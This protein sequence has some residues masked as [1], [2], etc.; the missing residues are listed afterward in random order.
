MTSTLHV[1]LAGLIDYAGLFPPAGESMEAATAKY[2]RYLEGPFR[3]A[4]GRFLVGVGRLTELA[5]AKPDGQA[6]RLGVLVGGEVGS[7]VEAARNFARAQG[8]RFTVDAFEARAADAAALEEAMRAAPED[9][10][11]FFEIPLEPDPTPMLEMLAGTRFRAKV[12][13]GGVTAGAIPSTAHLARFLARAAALG[14]P[15]KA[16]AGLHHPLRGPAALTYEKDSARAMMHGF[17]NLTGA[18]ALAWEGMTESGLELVLRE[19][20]RDAF[21]FSE[22]SVSIGGAVLSRAQLEG[23]RR[24]FALGFGSCSFE[25]PLDGLR[26]M[27]LL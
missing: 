1:L 5:G 21:G 16:T 27:R 20:R 18:A 17:L 19:E 25:E 10:E 22:N 4:L 12:R 23:A 14:V 8:G 3:F 7:G 26:E 6:W 15:F 11:V 2:S 9:A 13:T 24:L